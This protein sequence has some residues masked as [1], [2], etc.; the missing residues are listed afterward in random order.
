MTLVKCLY[1]TY[2]NA[3]KIIGQFFLSGTYLLFNFHETC[4]ISLRE[5]LT[6]GH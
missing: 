1:N 3:A 5:P 4:D 6:D 2:F